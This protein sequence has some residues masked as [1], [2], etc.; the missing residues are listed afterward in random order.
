MRILVNGFMQESISK[1]NPA[2]STVSATLSR[3]L[4][5]GNY[6]TLSCPPQFQQRENI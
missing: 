3:R 6:E 1:T 2:Q 4:P 5:G